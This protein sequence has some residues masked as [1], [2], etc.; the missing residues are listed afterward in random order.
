M[1]QTENDPVRDTRR[2]VV[3]LLTTELCAS[4][5]SYASRDTTPVRLG[6]LTMTRIQ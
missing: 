3:K 1:N 2:G 5:K 6:V 4:T